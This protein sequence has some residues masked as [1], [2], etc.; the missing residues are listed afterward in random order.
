MHAFPQRCLSVAAFVRALNVLH[1]CDG[2]H[3]PRWCL[4]KMCQAFHQM[5]VQIRGWMQ[6]EG[7]DQSV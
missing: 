3:P 1:R 4:Q 5:A 6:V 7:V 2:Q